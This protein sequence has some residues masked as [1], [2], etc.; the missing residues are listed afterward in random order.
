MLR[1]FVEDLTESNSMSTVLTKT[2]REERLPDAGETPDAANPEPS[3]RE[4]QTKDKSGAERKKKAK[5][6]G[7]EH[8]IGT[9]R[10]IETLFRS[11]YRVNMNLNALADNKSN[12]MISVNAIIIS[13]TLASISPKIDANPYLLVPTITLLLGCLGSM[14]MA[15]LA[16]RPRV[17]SGVVT[18]DDVRANRANILF[19]GSFTQLE[20]DDYL[21]GMLEM[22]RSTDLTYERM[23]RDTY[24][25]GRVLSVKYRLLRASYSFFIVALVAGV[26]SFV[27]ILVQWQAAS[28]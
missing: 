1:Y 13:I 9:S 19:F 16:A 20:E 8:G 22:L 3:E 6:K 17:K 26:L 28:L 27:W 7:S 12:I 21:E 2:G 15:I 24:A 23:L 25:R 18:L 5:K 10:G 11:Q 14:I 4:A